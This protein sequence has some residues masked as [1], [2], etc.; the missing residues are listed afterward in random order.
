MPGEDQ[1]L[2]EF[3]GQLEPKLLG[4]VVEVVFDKMKLAGEAG[5]LLKIE[6]E[7]RDAVAAAKKQWVRETTQ[8]TDKKGRALLFTEAEM[9]RLAGK[10]EQPS[11]F[12]LTDITDDQFFEQAEAK[13]GEALRS[14]A[15]KAQ[16]GQKLQRC[17]SQKMP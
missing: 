4:Q 2:K 11:L 13:V 10:P 17:S 8:A 9:E 7:I 6:E 1:M 3:V 15:E 5:S 12:D 16:N 14:Y